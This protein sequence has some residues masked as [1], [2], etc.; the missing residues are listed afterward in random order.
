MKE[1]PRAILVY[2]DTDEMK[3]DFETGQRIFFYDE[4]IEELKR[5]SQTN[6]IKVVGYVR[7]DVKHV[8]PA[9]LIGSGKIAEL[10][11]LIAELGANIVI[12]YNELSPTQQRNINKEID[13]EVIDRT[14][15]ILDI[16][17]GR[18]RSN[19]GKLQV[20]LAKLIYLST[21]LRGKGVELSRIAGGMQ[22]K[23]PGEK[24]L[25]VQKRRIK[26]R[27]TKIRHELVKVRQTREIHRKNRRKMNMTTVALVGYTNAGKSTLLN[28]LANESV[29][30]ED[31]LFATLD[32]TTRKL[33]LPNDRRVLIT[34][35][36]GFIHKLPKQLSEAFKATFEEVEEADILLH[37]IDCSHMYME[38][39]AAT[40]RL[41]FH[42]MG[43]EEKPIINLYNKVDLKL[44]DT[45]LIESIM[46]R[47]DSVVISSIT[48]FGIKEMLVKICEMLDR[49]GF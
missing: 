28:Y 5:L 14:S 36:V 41:M 29:L 46:R 42:E 21:R 20:E 35:T 33:W 2:A 48:G 30:A 16:F 17:A 39:Q 31:K 7:Q 1:K 10:K 45:D 3:G 26:D 44:D 11:E 12:F 18:A 23:G 47:P 19:E 37:V 9:T 25:E 27:I 6:R 13:V 40:V 4:A 22:T 8:S 34:D 43:I 32:P 24:K 15:L 38:D 49:Y